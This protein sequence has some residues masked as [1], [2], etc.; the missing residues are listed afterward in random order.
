MIEKQ[1][2]ILHRTWALSIFT[3]VHNEADNTLDAS[4]P[5]LFIVSLLRSHLS[6]VG[7]G[8]FPV[9]WRVYNQIDILSD[10]RKAETKRLVGL[11][12]VGGAGKKTI[13]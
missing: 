3:S 12:R 13:T 2:Y 5:S 9:K 7:D 11:D 8:L 6:T 1:D 4:D 10:F